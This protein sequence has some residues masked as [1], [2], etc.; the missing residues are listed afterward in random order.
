M[1]MQMLAAGGMPLLTD[2]VRAP[3]WDNPRGYFEFEPVKRT[4][5]DPSWVP[6][7]VGKAV[8]M[9]TV[10]LRDLPPGFDYRVILIYRDPEEILASQKAMLGR[11]GRKG[12]EAPDEQLKDLF[13]KELERASKWMAAQPNF[14]TL[15][16][17][18]RDCIGDPVAVAG[19]VNA[20]LDGKRDI[21]KM[22]GVV[23]GTLYRKIA[24]GI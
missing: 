24:G 3:D 5:E 23:D 2:G 4:R 22:A 19:S 1:M 10:L 12:A 13:Q 11:L 15:A 20:F 16:V 17:S 6:I 21:L 18:Y 14:R 8:K 9:V 7:A